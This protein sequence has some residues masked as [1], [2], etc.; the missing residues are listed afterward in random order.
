LSSFTASCENDNVV[1]DWVTK[2]EINNDYFT[3]EKSDDGV[4]WTTL[5]IVEG[6]DNSSVQL[7]Y[8]IVD[9][10]PYSGTTYYRLKQTDND[11]KHEYTEMISVHNCNGLDEQVSY[12]VYPNPSIGLMNFNS[13]FDEDF[14]IFVT[15]I[16]GRE[17][18]KTYQIKQG[19]NQ[20]ELS[21]LK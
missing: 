20:L 11:G 6:A 2:S 5:K 9:S 1:I 10:N 16:S 21:D 3:V 14:T 7:D 12:S 18:L 17:V 13:D 4:N 8:S 15:D 19:T